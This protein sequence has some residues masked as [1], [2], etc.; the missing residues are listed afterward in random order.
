[1]KRKLAFS[2]LLALLLCLA[3]PSF[4]SASFSGNLSYVTDSAGILTETQ[5]Q[6]LENMAAGIS[7]KYQCGVYIVTTQDYTEFKRG[8]ISN[9]AEEIYDRYLHGFGET[10]DGILLLLSMSDRDYWV[11][12]HG[13]FGNYA[14][15]Y[16]V[17]DELDESFLRYFRNDDWYGGFKS[18]LVFAEQ[19]LVPAVQGYPAYL[20][21][22]QQHRDEQEKVVAGAKGV[23]SVFAGL[24][25]ALGVC[26][27]MKRQMKTAREKDDADEY[28]TPTSPHMKIVQDHFLNRTRT[29]QVIP[30]ESRDSGGYSGGHSGGG[31]SGHSG[32]GGKF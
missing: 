28:M 15:P 6:E 5:R 3:L 11:D 4:A 9:C 24:L 14:F 30:Q 32:H 2:L 20:E 16:E 10:G 23:G 29:V 22:L 8:S 18:F 12:V 27:G 19:L 1:M 25:T 17:N 21:S 31:F 26:S 7:E 13:S